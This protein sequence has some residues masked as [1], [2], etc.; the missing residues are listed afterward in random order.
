MYLVLASQMFPQA[1][2]LIT[3]YLVFSATGLLNTYL[4]L[5]LSFTTFTLP[6]CVWMLK[7]F[8]DTIPDELIEAAKVDG[9]GRGAIIHRILLP[10]ACPAWSPPACSRSSAAGTTSSSRSPSPD[11]RSRPCHPA[12]ST[13]TWASSGG[14]ARSDGRLARRLAPVVLGFVLLQ[15]YLVA[16]LTSGAVKG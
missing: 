10:I 6:L 16:G 8:F 3:L 13:P 14:L 15:R 5:I 4:A 9:A 11:R 7:G 12:W 2:L 1:L